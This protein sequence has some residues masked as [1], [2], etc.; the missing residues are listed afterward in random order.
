MP[1]HPTIPLRDLSQDEFD[2]LDAVVMRHA[3][4]AQ[5]KLGRLFD[6]R[7]YENEVA[8]TLREAGHE[9]HTQTPMQVI[10]DT[11]E[12]TYFLD[13][14]VDQM[15]Y[16]LK[17]VAAL[18][19]EHDAQALHYAMLLNV[20]RTKLI[21]FRPERVHGKLCFNRL[22]EA[23]RHAPHFETSSWKSQ[24]EA[25]DRL[26][27]VLREITGD[28]GTHLSTRLYTEAL[29]H[30][31][32]G[33]A[34]CLQRVPVGALGTHLIQSHAAGLAFVL[35]SLTRGV[36]DYGD[37]LLRLKRHLEITAVHWFYLN[38]ATIECRT[39]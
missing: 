33:E 21:N 9:V 30:F 36:E 19:P 22:S 17:T 24:G 5:N 4:A 8:R 20:R 18:A 25:C 29:I 6:E 27:R 38:H 15:L 10:H 14:I 28:W 3:Y 7:V 12:T 16:E 11:F 32:G 2:R 35:T 39:M 26:L 31:H 13:L 23:D 1:I 37:H 34:Q